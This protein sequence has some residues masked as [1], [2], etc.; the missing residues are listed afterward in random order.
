MR[1]EDL[2]PLIRLILASPDT[3]LK[4]V[5]AKRVRKQLVELNPALTTEFVK[6]NKDELNSLIGNIFKSLQ[7]AEEDNESI[8]DTLGD[9][10]PNGSAN[11]KRKRDED[12]KSEEPEN[13]SN[14]KEE[15]DESPEPAPSSKKA[16]KS[17]SQKVTDEE[18]AR[19]LSS[20]LNQ[21]PSRSRQSNGTSKKS[22]S[23]APKKRKSRAE[24]DDSEDDE[25]TD[26][27]NKRRKSKGT[28]KKKGTGEAKGGFAKELTLSEP[29][30]AVVD[31][32]QLSRPQVVKR[33]WAYIKRNNLQ[34]PSNRKEILC[35]TSLKAIFNSEKVDMFSM[36]KVLSQHL[37]ELEP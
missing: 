22:A 15:S 19:M 6:E 2:G 23:K 29:L 11:G 21:R 35:D 17:S 18:Y 20:E 28:Q 24:I 7:K 12:I 33:L 27:N 30:A 9:S 14:Q 3:D 16:K 34:N 4:T 1:V 10:Q 26:G 37:Y 8:A 36:N 25:D 5:S 31:A 32:A 13:G